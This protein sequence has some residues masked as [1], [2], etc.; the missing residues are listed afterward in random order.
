MSNQRRWDQRLVPLDVDYDLLVIP[1]ATRRHFGNPIRPR[2]VSGVR[3][4]DG[5]ADFRT[6]LR[7]TLV[8]GC[9]ETLG[10]TALTRA[11]VDPSD[12]RPTADIGEGLTR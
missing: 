2:G 7:N 10:C 8:V 5:R 4:F 1:S 6:R 11:L 12:H 9:D 3:H